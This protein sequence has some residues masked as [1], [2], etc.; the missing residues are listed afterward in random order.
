MNDERVEGNAVSAQT[1]RVLW[2]TAVVLY[3][4]ETKPKSDILQSEDSA[5]DYTLLP[6]TLNK[7]L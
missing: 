3:N 2:E 6:A 1:R 7:R 5:F 4:L